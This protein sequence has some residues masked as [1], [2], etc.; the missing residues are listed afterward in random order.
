MNNNLFSGRRAT[1]EK[2]TSAGE[3]KFRNYQ[4]FDE[5][6][7][8]HIRM[9]SIWAEPAQVYVAHNKRFYGVILLLNVDCVLLFQQLAF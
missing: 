3:R 4:C 7:K 8:T 2:K 1:N 5:I 6:H 9:L